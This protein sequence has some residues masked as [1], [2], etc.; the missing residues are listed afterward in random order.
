MTVG[1][2]KELARVEA[3]LVEAQ[4]GA[5]GLL[6]IT[7]EAGIGKSR[8]LAR[9]HGLAAHSVLAA[10]VVTSEGRLLRIDA[11]HEPELF[12]A[13]RGGGGSFAAVTALEIRL[14]PFREATAGLLF[15]PLE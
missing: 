10:E 4:R 8:V 11:H 9:R 6:M 1:R 13:I 15:F 7:G 12:W 14:I 3:G 2:D 5:G